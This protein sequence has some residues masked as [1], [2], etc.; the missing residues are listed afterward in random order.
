MVRVNP[1]NLIIPIFIPHMGCPHQCIFCNQRSISGKTAK[2]PSPKW[3]RDE[4]NRFLR[5]GK[6]PA[7][8][9]QI[10]FFGGNFLGLPKQVIHTLLESVDPFV[11][12]GTVE[13]LRFSTRPD[14]V[15]RETLDTLSTFPVSTVE[16]GVQ[17]MNDRVLRAAE[18]GHL[19]SDTVKAVGLLK[20]KRYSVGLQMMVGLPE[21]N[22]LRAMQTAEQIKELHP[23][24]VR[25][26]PTVV[27]KGSKLAKQ[28]HAG[29]Y[30]P[31]ELSAC[32]SL[33]KKIY[34]HFKSRSIAVIRMGLQASEGLTLSK[35]LLAGPYHPAFGHLVLSEIAYDSISSALIHSNDR[36]GSLTLTCHPSRVSRVQGLKK[37]NYKKL[38]NHFGIKTIQLVQDP[39]MPADRLL[40]EDQL[41]TVP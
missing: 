13:S 25:I 16:L 17:S 40:V 4:V 18:R 10:S 35:D 29:R 28:F 15:N 22:D 11:A 6:R 9:V 23:D 27:L 26:Y 36:K 1:K 39:N 19:S 8:S 34:L 38:G 37:E 14:T 12:C 7:S 33:V 20:E 3:I 32:V 21:D 41:V 24:F 30:R 2:I 5:Y 31:M